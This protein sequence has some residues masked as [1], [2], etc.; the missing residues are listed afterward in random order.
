MK[1]LSICL[2]ALYAVLSATADTRQWEEGPL[3][4]SD[5]SGNPVMKATPTYFKGELKIVTDIEQKET[6]RFSSETTF[7]ISAVAVMDKSSSY[8]D[9][10]YCSPQA[11]RYHQ[12]QF[13]MLE[14]LRRRLQSDLNNGMAGLE[15]D[16]R[17]AYYQRIYEEQLSDLARATVNGSNDRRL[18]DYEYMT[19]KQLDEYML[20]GVPE[21]VSGKFYAGWFAGTGVLVPTGE[22][23][24]L[25][26]YAWIFNIGLYGGYQRWMLKADISYGQ[27]D[28]KNP[29]HDPFG[30]TW[31]ESRRYMASDSYSK[32]LS[33]SVAIGFRIVDSKRFAVTPHIGGGWTNYAWNY[34]EY[35]YDTTADTWDIASA[36]DKDS[37]HDFNIMGGIDFDWR[38]HTVVSEKPFFMSGKREQYTSSL[39]LTPY[40]IY[41]S[42]SSLAPSVGGVQVGVNL[43]YSGF[44]RALKIR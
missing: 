36:V 28:M 25:F 33:G 12:L 16:S 18:Q 41:Q 14:I 8:A 2:I 19:R 24:G 1:R 10:A 42:Y 23:S 32:Q 30:R 15:A 17:R 11:L 7:A 22:I 31:G 27:P 39:R 29:L 13:D 4:W 5:F 6:S 34:A 37:F 40:I 9:T 20:P 35:E 26:D 21:V 44:V 43:T 38:F 3:R